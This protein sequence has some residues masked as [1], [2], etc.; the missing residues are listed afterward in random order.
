M[1]VNEKT[2]IGVVGLGYV[3]LPLA[4]A[5]GRTACTV[6]GID[7]S[8]EK[9]E[10]LKKNVDLNDELTED[11]LASSDVNYGTDPSV[12]AHCDVIITA[13]PTPINAANVP[14]LRMM[15]SASETIAK[16]MKA[17]AIV[18]FESTVY[19]G[20]T[21]EICVP[22]LEE[23]S[24]LKF[25]QD[26]KVGYSPERINPG[27]REHTLERIVKVV[28]G[29]D[30]ETLETLS[31]LYGLVV[32]AGIHKAPS[33]KVAEA[34][35]VI[36]NIQR[37]LNIALVNELAIIFEKVGIPTQDV[38]AAAGTKWNFH[39]Y[40]PGLVGGHCIGVD[41][42]YL[43]FKAQ[44]LGY[45]PQIILA[46]RRV[47]DT[48]HQ[49][50]VDCV[51][52]GLIGQ[53]VAVRDAKVLVLGVTFKENVSDVRNSKTKAL[54]EALK[55]YQ[56]DV[57]AHDPL[58]E[59]ADIERRFDVATVD[60]FAPDTYDAIVLTAPHQSIVAQPEKLMATLKR[61]GIFMDIKGVLREQDWG[62]VD[63]LAL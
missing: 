3:G 41:P 32:K 14:D 8:E 42:Y 50:V 61:P 55:A 40:R 7:I 59:N 57:V 62:D 23:H 49:H 39:P 5:F 26:F 44:Q 15:K 11:E 20:V 30:D 58:V 24:G 13:I 28:A 45:H 9:V 60:D 51:V 53:G 31:E 48:M 33:I 56:L 25:G 63:Y 35:K 19:P 4:V 47:N 1:S 54:I 2:I 43:T 22:I 38:L 16:H 27:D 37:D 36:E 52:K 6:Y 17:G 12:L 46:G 29:S 21:E 10:A 18:V 34:A